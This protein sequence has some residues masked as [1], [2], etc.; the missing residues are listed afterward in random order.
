[1][2]LTPDSCPA[3]HV[4]DKNA[5]VNAMAVLAES[6]IQGGEHIVRCSK[7]GESVLIPSRNARMMAGF[8]SLYLHGALP[9]VK[10]KRFV[11]I[12]Y[13]MEQV[14]TWQHG[15]EDRIRKAQAGKK[16]GFDR[17]G[18]PYGR[19]DPQ[20]MKA[21]L[22]RATGTAQRMH[23]ESSGQPEGAQLS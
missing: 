1:M 10:G 4:D 12:F 8:H 15:E 11:A 21:L 14:V 5:G 9:I 6:D 13:S 17:N 22:N 3:L 7:D 16:G 23:P 20:E 18:R 2:T 19:I